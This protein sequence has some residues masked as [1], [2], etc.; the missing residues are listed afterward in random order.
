M[1]FSSDVIEK[2]KWLFIIV[3]IAAIIN[4]TYSVVVQRGVYLDGATLFLSALNKYASS[5][6]EFAVN[7][8]QPRFFLQSI[9]QLPMA[10]SYSYFGVK[11]KHIL[12]L[13]FSLSLFLYPLLLLLWNYKLTQKTKRYDIF[14]FSILVYLLFLLPFSIFSAAENSIAFLLMFVL[15]NFIVGEYEYSSNDYILMLFLSVIM[16][17]SYEGIVV[18][19]PFLMLFSLYYAHKSDSDLT[20][21]IKHLVAGTIFSAVIFNIVFF[22]S[23]QAALEEV[24]LNASKLF[25]WTQNFF[26]LNTLLLLPFFVL[27]PFLVVRKKELSVF[28]KLAIFFVCSILFVFMMRNLSVFIVPPLEEQLRALPMIFVP[29]IFLL[30]FV[31]TLFNKKI[32]QIVCTNLLSLALICGIFQIAWQINNSYWFNKNINFM[33]NKLLECNTELC[34]LDDI[35]ISSYNN[36]SLRRFI[37]NYNYVPYSIIF[38]KN[39]NIDRILMPPFSGKGLGESMR[40]NI[41]IKDEM[42]DVCFYLVSVKNDFWDLTEAVKKL[43][44]K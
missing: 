11:S 8:Y 14:V 2:N 23:N 33:R 25:S 18:I 7:D 17:G 28:I 42:L 19:G 40:E 20:K 3:V 41:K 27:L 44:H 34:Y 6:F 35:E 21:K 10:I 43:D 9:I 13:L 36:S 22:L 1:K 38:S 24:K 4:V 39:R 30:L 29:L 26:E 5:S 15:L 12:S 16:F 31:L 37:W 32:P